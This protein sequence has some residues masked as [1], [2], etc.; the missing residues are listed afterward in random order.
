MSKSLNTSDFQ[1]TP[2]YTLVLLWALRVF[3][4]M[5]TLMLCYF[6]DTIIH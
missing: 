6:V 5:M 3:H 2:V 4:G 1:Y